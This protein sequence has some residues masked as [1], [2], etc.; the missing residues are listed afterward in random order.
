[1]KYFLLLCQVNYNESEKKRKEEA[2]DRDLTGIEPRYLESLHPEFT[3]LSHL[4]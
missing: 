1:M 2:E 3:R 4:N